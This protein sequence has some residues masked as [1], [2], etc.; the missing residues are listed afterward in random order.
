MLQRLRTLDI[1]QAEVARYGWV[2][3]FMAG[4]EF[5]EY[6]ESQ[7]AFIGELMTELGFIGE[8]R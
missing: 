7:E 3:R 2:E 5:V 8:S 1:W 4:D 6:L